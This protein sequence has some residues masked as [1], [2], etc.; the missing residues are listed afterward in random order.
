[1][2]RNMRK[3]RIISVLIIIAFLIFGI[4]WFVKADDSDLTEECWIADQVLANRI[5]ENFDEQ[6][7]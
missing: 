4:C 3:I 1:M 6:R 7:N 5:T 2:N